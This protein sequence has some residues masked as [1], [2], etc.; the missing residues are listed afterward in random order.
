MTAKWSKILLTISFLYHL[1]A[2]AQTPQW[3]VQPSVCITNSIGSSCQL[4]IK[5]TT[6]NLPANKHCIFL[7]GQQIQCSINGYS[8]QNVT[9]NIK[10]A[11]RLELR[12]HNQQTVL[13]QTL[14]IKYQNV[15]TM[16]RRIRN[17]WSIF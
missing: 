7:D 10:Q 8:G 11:A 1:D 2:V 14:S 15:P 12:N 16:R 3:T 17:P 6:Q 13:T 9:L 5:I 4:T